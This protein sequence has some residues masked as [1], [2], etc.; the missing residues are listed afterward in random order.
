MK[1]KAARLSAVVVEAGMQA[2]VNYTDGRSFKV[3]FSQL[4]E[5]LQAFAPLENTIEFASATVADFGWSLE[6]DCGAS[7]DSD[8]VLELAL[9]QLG[10]AQ[11]VQF[12]HRQDRHHLSLTTAANALG[13][14]RRTISQYRTGSRPVP[15]YI[16]LACKGWE[17]EQG[18]G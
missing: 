8:R 10:M 7:L 11:N 14:T 5:R 2:T 6:W 1:K 15:L 18:C 4:A 13:M 3:A 17:V 16:A 9:E 12:R